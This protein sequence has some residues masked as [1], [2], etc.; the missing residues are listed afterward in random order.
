MPETITPLM[1]LPE[2]CSTF[3]AAKAIGT[4]YQLSVVYNWMIK[5]VQTNTLD[6]GEAN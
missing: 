5:R 2:W 6:R 3:D 4:F 1:E